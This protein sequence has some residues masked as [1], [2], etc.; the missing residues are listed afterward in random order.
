MAAELLK[1]ADAAQYEAFVKD[2]PNGSFMQSV[3]WGD[4]KSNW[5]RELVVSRSPEGKLRGAMMVLIRRIPVIGRSLLYAPHGPVCNFADRETMRELLVDGIDL[6]KQ[7]YR[8]TKFT[9]DPL[10]LEDDEE[11]IRALTELGYDFTPGAA[12]FKT[13]QIRVNYMLHIEG[14]TAEEVFAGFTSKCR[15]NVRLAG[16]HG[17]RCEIAGEE[18][19]DEFYRLMQVTGKRDDFTIRSKEYFRQ[20]LRAYGENARLYLC[21]YEDKAI[22]GALT[23]QYAGR[24]HYVYGAS[25]NEYRNVMPNYLMQWEMIQW[26]IEGGSRWYDFGF[27][28]CYTDENSHYYGLYRFKRS[29]GGEVVAYAGDFNRVLA[30]GAQRLVDFALST[31]RHLQSLK[32]KLHHA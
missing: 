22:S 26:A 17:V 4:V 1:P 12:D 20:M 6:L 32:H 19:L 25:D 31:L 23:V 28:P 7:K 30:P 5:A 29:F 11:G 10:I 18:G 15:Y 2:H 14:K 3:Q 8:A 21:Y 24:T 13:M 27:I 16:R 9:C